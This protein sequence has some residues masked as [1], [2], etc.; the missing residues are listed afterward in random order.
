MITLKFYGELIRESRVIYKNTVITAPLNKTVWSIWN[1]GDERTD[2]VFF[3][4]FNSTGP[5]IAGAQRAGFGS[6]LTTEQAAAFNISSAIGSDFATWVD[7]SY[8]G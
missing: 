8:L 2:N 7:T 1:V 4:D 3:A 5:G 6:Q